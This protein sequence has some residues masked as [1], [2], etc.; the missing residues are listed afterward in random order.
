MIGPRYFLAYFVVLANLFNLIPSVSTLHLETNP[1]NGKHL[2]VLAMEVYYI[3][4]SRIQ[5][6]MLLYWISPLLNIFT[7]LNSFLVS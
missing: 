2:R 4:F 5:F 6:Y 7:L 3:H 1:L